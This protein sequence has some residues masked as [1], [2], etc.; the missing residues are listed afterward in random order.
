MTFGRK[1]KEKRKKERNEIVQREQ[2][3][4]VLVRFK[5]ESTLHSM[6]CTNFLSGEEMG[7]KTRHFKTGEILH[8][9]SG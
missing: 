5:S 1:K 7:G 2:I 8:G 4:V 3:S 9:L 6:M